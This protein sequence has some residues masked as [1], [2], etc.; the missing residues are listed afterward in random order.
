[1]HKNT[2]VASVVI[3]EHT[4][5]IEKINEVYNPPHLPIGTAS[6]T[7]RDGER[8]D[9]ARLNNWWC[10]RA[11]PASRDGFEGILIKLGQISNSSLALRCY[12]LSLSDHYWASPEGSSLKWNEI[13]FFQNEFSKDI[14]E[15]LFGKEIISQDDVDMMSPDNTSDGWLKKKWIISNGKR[16][17]MKGGSGDYQQEPLNEVI[18]CEIMR[19]LD[20]EHVPYHVIFDEGYPYSLCETFVTTDTELVPAWRIFNHK[21]KGNSDSELT[22][23]LKCCEAL[24]I[25]NVKD[26]I[27]KLITL[28][29]II[30]NSDRH[31]N[32][33][34]FVRNPDTLEWYGPAPVYDSGTSLWHNTQYIYR[35][36]RGRERDAKPFKKTH[37]EQLKLVD[38]LNWFD[39]GMLKGLDEACINIF[40]RSEFISRERR[41]AI[42]GVIHER[43]Q[44]VATL[45]VMLNRK[46]SQD[47]PKR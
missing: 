38:N 11:I 25:P 23:L 40:A 47:A 15:I 14:G 18:A 5:T 37:T 3:S 46:H 22:H 43:T 6:I 12:G 19:R 44:H 28:D 30:A 20:I 1:M 42:A 34:G 17:L 16:L 9:L 36:P 2:L 32:N 10:G 31:Y 4:G 33:F 24:G 27:N 26:G 29:Y 13:N 39:A 21:P 7:R 8:L 41:K 45:K 35:P